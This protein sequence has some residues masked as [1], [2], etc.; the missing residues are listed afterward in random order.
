[1]FCLSSSLSMAMRKLSALE[2]GLLELAP[3]DIPDF[4]LAD[5]PTLTSSRSSSDRCARHSVLL[6]MGVTKARMH[7]SL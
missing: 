3:V 1:M 7:A 5:S 2:F 6:P 4:E